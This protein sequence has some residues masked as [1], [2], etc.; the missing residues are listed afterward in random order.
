MVRN[1]LEK[2]NRWVR[3]AD[4]RD[5]VGTADD[6]SWVESAVGPGAHVDVLWAGYDRA[7]PPEMIPQNLFDRLFEEQR[8]CLGDPGV[9]PVVPHNLLALPYTS[10]ELLIASTK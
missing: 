1:G 4:T 7:L 3:C 10:A 5:G 9:P 8:A 6:R 2:R